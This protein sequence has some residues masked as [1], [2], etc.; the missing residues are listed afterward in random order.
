MRPLVATAITTQNLS[1][2]LT[3]VVAGDELTIEV[4]QPHTAAVAVMGTAAG[5]R[6]LTQISINKVR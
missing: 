4:Y 5:P 3:D 6:G 1:W 2:T